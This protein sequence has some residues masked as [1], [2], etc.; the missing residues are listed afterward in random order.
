MGSISI[1]KNT[2]YNIIKTASTILFPIITFPYISRVLQPKNIGRINFGNSIVGYI[3]L[4]ATLGVTTYAI[5]ECS[6][7]RNN[8]EELSKLSGEILSIN[9][10]TTFIAYIVLAIILLVYGKLHDYRLLILIQSLSVIFTALGAD[11]INTAMED[12][13]Y[14]TIRT[15]AFQVLSVI[16]MFIFVK[17]PNDYINYAI[18]TVLSSSGAGILNII[19][20][21]KYCKTKFTIKCSLKKHLPPI[22]GL[23]AMLLAQQVF[24][25]SDTTIIGLTLG[26]Y[27]VGLYSTAV[28]IYNIL[29]Q[30]LGSITWVVMAQL[31]VAFAEDSIEDIKRI[32]RYVI[33]FSAV[34]GIPCIVGL[35]ILSPEIISIFG[36]RSYIEATIPLRLLSLTLA[37][38]TIGNY[39]FNINLLAAG[40]DKVCLFACSMSAVLNIITNIIFIPVFGINAA[41][42]TTIVSQLCAAI[43]CIPFLKKK[44]QDAENLKL[45]LRPVFASVIMAVVLIILKYVINNTIMRVIVSVLFGAGVYFVILMTLH[46]E[47]TVNTVQSCVSKLKKYYLSHRNNDN[48]S[49]FR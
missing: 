29:N 19:Y 5:R 15:I 37:I 44:Y 3:S 34:F 41:A 31:S 12:F 28:K 46:D 26:D 30:I 14:I 16:L 33:Q 38:S 1:K 42:V 32:L 40:K 27:Q 43:I 35:F 20:R 18:I 49:D 7:V 8:R 9:L 48:R 4:L 2:V 22:L 39:I 13:K 23:F 36:G 21:R 45:V 10:F 25:M 24:T 11:W 47:F 17:E 6:K